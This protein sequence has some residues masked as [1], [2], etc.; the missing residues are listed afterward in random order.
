M[1]HGR[2]PSSGRQN[3]V[4]KLLDAVVRD[5]SKLTPDICEEAFN[6]LAD[7]FIA[8]LLEFDAGE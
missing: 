7:H 6:K 5:D 8:K 4:V 1:S 3:S 2:G